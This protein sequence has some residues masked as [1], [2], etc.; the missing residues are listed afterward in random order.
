MAGLLYGVCV[1]WLLALVG[2]L[3]RWRWGI[4]DDECGSAKGG[5]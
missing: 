3:C 5:A 2:H 4:S 1:V